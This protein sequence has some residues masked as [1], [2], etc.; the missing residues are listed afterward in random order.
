MIRK[1]ILGF[2]L[3]GL[4]SC[5]VT[6]NH[7]SKSEINQITFL[8]EYMIPHNFVFDSTVVGGLSGIDYDA[9]HDV[10][11]FI[12]DDRSDFNPARF[13]TAKILINN[14][15]I[16]TVIFQKTTFFKNIQ[17]KYYPNRKQ[18][19]NFTP[20][21]ESLRYDAVSNTFI[22]TDEGERIVN[23]NGVRLLNPGIYEINPQGQLLDSFQLPSQFHMTDKN[24]GPRQNGVFE[25]MT[26]GDGNKTIYVSTEEPLLNDGPRAGLNDSSAIIRIIKFDRKTKKQISQFVYEIDPVA[27]T[28]TPIDGFRVNGI[29]DILYVG[30]NQ[31]LVIERSFS[32]GKMSC[33]I[34]LYLADLSN[35]TDVSKENYLEKG[36]VKTIPKKL[37]LNMDDLGIFIDNIEGVTFGPKLKNG[38]RSLLFVADNNFNPFEKTQILLFEI[39]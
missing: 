12:C 29:S 28:P 23:A 13:Y 21:P 30:N 24:F 36:K 8:N 6:K 10:Y 37:L 38:N 4:F 1:F 3:C 26:F 2:I 31:L 32:T 16:D 7:S 17:G 9:T 27:T 15:K 5:T 19:A 18:D 25:G 20:D 39:H 33:T 14:D 34:K 22:W 35:A 11:H